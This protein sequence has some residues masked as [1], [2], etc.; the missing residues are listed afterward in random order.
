MQ[1][2]DSRYP[3]DWI[4]IAEKDWSRVEHL[5]QAND[6]EAAAF[7]LQQA[8]EKFLKAF[9]LSRGWKLQRTHDL[10]AL[11]NQALAYDMSLEAFRAP[12]QKISGFYLIERYP[13]V[14]GSSVSGEDVHRATEE[15]SELVQR[16]RKAVAGKGSAN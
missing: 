10:E 8:A 3:A 5:L 15:V 12:C 1:H 7:F 11:L 14:A 16:L 6:A 2:D 13:M 9:L 4:A